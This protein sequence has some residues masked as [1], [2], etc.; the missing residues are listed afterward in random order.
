MDHLLSK[1]KKYEK[2]DVTRV[3]EFLVS[4]ERSPK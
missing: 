3:E 4:F 1:E 2:E